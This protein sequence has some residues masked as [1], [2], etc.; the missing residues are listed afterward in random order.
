MLISCASYREIDFKDRE[1]G[2]ITGS[3]FYKRSSSHAWKLRD[4]LAVTEILN[5]NVPDFMRKFVAI[6]TAVESDQG[7]IIKAT[8][9]VSP[10]YLS[11]GS[12]D[13]WA[14][15][16][17]TPMAAQAIADTLHCFLP[18]RKIVDDI[19]QHA[20]VKLE[21]VA[22][23]AFR[24]S[25]PTMYQHHLMIEGLRKQRSG[26]IAGIKKDVVISGKVSRAGLSV[27]NTN[28]GTRDTRPNR[29]A[30]YGWHK[31]DAKAIQP[32][33]TGHVNWYV[34]YSHGIRLVYR[35]IKV[36]GKWMD[37]TDVL[38][39]PVLQKLICDEDHCDF[40]RY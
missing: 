7:K 35:R 16:P 33:Y 19:Y 17:L 4:S 28:N 24:D 12:D 1:H 9:Y 21:P 10:D 6:Q 27:K 38:K 23:F 32:L 29:V 14:R 11:I 31:P 30:I 36:D 26:M 34:D 40:Y 25:T 8:Y 15:I 22:M 13:D 20:R 3:E 39:D 37:Y 2:A 5:G 18:T